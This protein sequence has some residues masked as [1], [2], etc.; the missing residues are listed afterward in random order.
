MTID[1]WSTTAGDNDDAD[2]AINWLENQAPSTVNNSARAMM[3]AIRT[4]YEDLEWRNWGDTVAYA[5]GTTFTI[6]GDVTARYPANRP[7]RC[8]D[9]T[10]LYGY[11]VSSSYGAPNTT[12]T[13]ALDS[14]SLSVSLTSVALGLI[15][16][17]PSIPIQAVRNGASAF[18]AAN[19]TFSGRT[20]FS[21]G[22]D[23]ASASSLSL[24]SDGNYFDI[25]GTVAITSIATVG[26]G[27]V[28]RLHFD[29]ALV[30]THH[31]TDLILP[32]GASITTAAGDEAEFVEYATGDW[33]C[34]NYT[35]ASGQ[36]VIPY[37][38]ILV[39]DEKAQNTDGGTFTSGAWRKRTIN[40]EV[41]DTGSN[42]SI[43]SDQIT[44]DAG[45]YECDIKCPAY[46]VDEHQA[47]LQNVTDASTTLLGTSER[48]ANGASVQSSS[49]IKGRFTIT[50]SKTFEVQHY[51]TA[52]NATTGFGFAVN[53]GTEI[54][55]VAEFRKIA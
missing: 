4:W 9:S 36:P 31:A 18:L 1:K 53:I 10:T 15:P 30:L 44:L 35:K 37:G 17:N 25:T 39:R 48:A 32:G 43:S 54:Y 7:I 34:T 24:G 2:P 13:V 6:S 49:V 14:G 46:Y 23:V 40:T 42:C 21:A 29:D 11:I 20:T 5:S 22:A 41:S 55:T 51:S 3:A 38:Y 8:A 52:T 47:R 28:V 50:A 26:V 27:T 16:S 19:N 33:R 12:V 45:T